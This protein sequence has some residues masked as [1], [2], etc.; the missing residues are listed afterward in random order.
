MGK[1]NVSRPRS[2][3]ATNQQPPFHSQR[4]LGGWIKIKIN[5]NLKLKKKGKITITHKEG[6]EHVEGIGVEGRL[7][8]FNI[9]HLYV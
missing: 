6:R 2:S 7:F 5:Q 4:G 1:T 8:F 9:L 3:R